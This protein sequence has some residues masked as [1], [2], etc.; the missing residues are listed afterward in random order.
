MKMIFAFALLLP[1][2]VF[3]E[4]YCKE[5]T[6]LLQEMLDMRN[7]LLNGGVM[8]SYVVEDSKTELAQFKSFCASHKDRD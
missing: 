2:N 3:A 7:R 6:T 1:L 4:E 5:K 8:S